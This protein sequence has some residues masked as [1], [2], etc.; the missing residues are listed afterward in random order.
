M[1]P[2]RS[3]LLGVTSLLSSPCFGSSD[4]ADAKAEDTIVATNPF[5]N[6][7]NRR[8]ACFQKLKIALM[9]VFVIPRL[10]IIL[11]A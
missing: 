4:M 7:T 11:R 9:A 10:L 8:I 3:L 5:V 2:R 1:L 6:E